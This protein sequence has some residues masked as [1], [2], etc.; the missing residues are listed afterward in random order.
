MAVIAS[1][2]SGGEDLFSYG[3]ILFDQRY[4]GTVFRCRDSCKTACA[5]ASDYDQFFRH[6]ISPVI[7]KWS[8]LK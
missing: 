4:V 7:T 1:A 5:S 8:Y 3:R 6:V 2:V